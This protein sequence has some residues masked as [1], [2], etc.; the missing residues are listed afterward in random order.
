MFQSQNETHPGAGAQSQQ[1]HTFMVIDDDPSVRVMLKQIIEKNKL[2]KVVADLSAGTHGAEEILFYNPDV[3]LIDYLLPGMD[4]VAVMEAALRQGYKGKFIM[5]SQ[6]EDEPM[7]S[8]AYTAG[9]V[10]FIGKP[11]NRIEVINVIRGV[12][13]NLELE[14]SMSLIQNAL[15]FM[16]GAQPKTQMSAQ[17][18][19]ANA[20][21]SAVFS[22]LGIVGDSGCKDLSRLVLR[23]HQTAASGSYQ[24][25]EIYKEIAEA[26][27]EQEGG[28]VNART[29]EQRIRRTIQKALANMAALGQEDPYN[30]KFTEYGTLLFDFPQVRQEM[31]YLDGRSKERGKISIKK[32][33][34]GVVSKLGG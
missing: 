8:K 32:F 4:G 28:S 12:A 34:E 19:D 30:T 21:L 25:Q 15:Q 10:F 17:P 3:V 7:V 14:R 22:D 2:G 20:K 24:L 16:G 31:K 6:V 18:Q 27:A 13:H 5:I 11:V 23:I 33:V 26:E 29:V 1:P 9:I